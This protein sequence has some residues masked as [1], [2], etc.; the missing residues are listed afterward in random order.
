MVPGEASWAT[1][2]G[3]VGHGLRLVMAQL[4]PSK[5]NTNRKKKH[6]FFKWLPFLTKLFRGDQNILLLWQASWLVPM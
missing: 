5:K 6:F 4:A 3:Q 1:F 2:M